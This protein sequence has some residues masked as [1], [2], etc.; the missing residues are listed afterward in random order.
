MMRVVRPRRSPR[1][2]SAPR[3][4]CGDTAPSVTM[5]TS[6]GAAAR[7]PPSHCSVDRATIPS[8]IT[9]RSRW[10]AWACASASSSSPGH[11][12]TPSTTACSA[13][14]ASPRTPHAAARST[15]KRPAPPDASTP[16]T[17]RARVATGRLRRE[18]AAALHHIPMKPSKTALPRAPLDGRTSRTRFRPRRRRFQTMRSYDHPPTSRSPRATVGSHTRVRACDEGTLPPRTGNMQG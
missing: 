11:P 5:P 10:I 8:A 4:T 1:F 16:R 14:S 3:T 13:S 17:R 15:S 18:S 7:P 2:A 12:G 6:A 9:A